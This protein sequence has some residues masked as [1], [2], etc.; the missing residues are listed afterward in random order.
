MLPEGR[1]SR[2]LVTWLVTG[3]AGYIGLHVVQAFKQRG[4][5][6]VVLDDLSTGRA[7][8]VDVPLVRGGVG[9]GEL[10]RRAMREHAVRGVVH[11]AAKRQVG[12]RRAAP[13]LRAVASDEAIRSS[14]PWQASGRCATWSPAPGRAG[15][16]R[17]AV[18]PD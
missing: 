1:L 6:V 8:R 7:D 9:D 4:E 11:L 13:V 18:A 5:D 14:L 16:I 2:A 15:R 12:E 10:L 3:G 17:P